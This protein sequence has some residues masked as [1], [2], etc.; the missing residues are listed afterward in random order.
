MPVITLGGV[1]YPAPATPVQADSQATSLEPNMVP[2][3]GTIA[4][5]AKNP[6]R[7]SYDNI[8]VATGITMRFELYSNGMKGAFLNSN[9]LSANLIGL[10]AGT[11][12]EKYRPLHTDTKYFIGGTAAY[13]T[14]GTRMIAIASNGL[15]YIY[16][17][18]SVGLYLNVYYV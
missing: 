11:V 2:T 9:T 15:M 4:N 14:N 1:D 12:P 17:S 5:W 3:G 18:A 6:I 7:V 8:T 10:P 13:E 16:K